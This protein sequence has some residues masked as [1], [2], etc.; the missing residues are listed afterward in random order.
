MMGHRRLGLFTKMKYFD[1]F[2]QD[3]HL[4]KILEALFRSTKA[5]VS[6]SENSPGHILSN[7]DP[8]TCPSSQNQ[9]L[10]NIRRA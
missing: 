9:K 5:M 2:V 8:K 4:K 7:F 10:E 3:K 1:V 6:I